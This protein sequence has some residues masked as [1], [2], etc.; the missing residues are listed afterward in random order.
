M[1]AHSTNPDVDTQLSPDSNLG[2]VE[3]RKDH[4]APTFHFTNSPGP[5]LPVSNPLDYMTS[6][7][8]SLIEKLVIYQ[9][10]FELP[11]D[12][13]VCRVS[14]SNCVTITS[15]LVTMFTEIPK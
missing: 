10:K 9:D 5:V 4:G 11:S 2:S 8:R 14:V 12:D 7:Q 13:D 3:S 6:E 15:V 1:K